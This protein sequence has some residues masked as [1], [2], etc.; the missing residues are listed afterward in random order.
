M[1]LESILESDIVMNTSRLKVDRFL[2]NR[3]SDRRAESFLTELANVVAEYPAGASRAQIDRAD[4]GIRRLVN[5]YP[6]VFP[7]PPTKSEIPENAESSIRNVDWELVAFAQKYLRLAWDAPD[8]RQRDWHI[9][10]ARSHYHFMTAKEPIH[11]EH[12]ERTG[13]L[14]NFSPAEDAALSRPPLQTPFERAM[15]H[16][17]E[18]GD[19]ARHCPNPE[20]PAPYF[21]A[22]KKGQKYC[23]SKC[24]APAQREQKRDW[25][26]QN[27]GKITT[28]RGKQ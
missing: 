23:S 19:R 18:I 21:F 13:S 26:R 15:C 16:F 4:E 17:H 10:E 24:S 9:F 12:F 2:G 11:R 20:C 1:Q 5:R 7:V 6:E 27:R 22:A 3:M 14:D 28:K 8:R 25:W